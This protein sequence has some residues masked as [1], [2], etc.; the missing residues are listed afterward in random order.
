M[1][2]MH[3]VAACE[4][5]CGAQQHAELV[6]PAPTQAGIPLLVL[7]NKNDLPEALSANELIA[8]LDLQ[9][10]QVG[11]LLACLSPAGATGRAWTLH[12]AAWRAGGCQHVMAALRAGV[13]HLNPCT[14]RCMGMVELQGGAIPDALAARRTGRPAST[15]SPAS[16]SPTST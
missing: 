6:L 3:A 13:A 14:W 8:R 10:V 12:P 4:L 1:V 7:G 11:A 9:G 15:P 16:G 2:Q 5:R